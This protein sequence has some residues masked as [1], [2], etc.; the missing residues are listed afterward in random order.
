MDTGWETAPAKPSHPSAF[1][2][3]AINGH[4]H[5]PIFVLNGKALVSERLIYL[6]IADATG[7]AAT[8]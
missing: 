2:F 1:A 3:W 4:V 8:K 7:F 6:C 5:A